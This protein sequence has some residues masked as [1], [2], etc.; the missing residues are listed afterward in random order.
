MVNHNDEKIREWY[1]ESEVIHKVMNAGLKIYHRVIDTREY[2]KMYRWVVMTGDDDYYCSGT[3]KCQKLKEQYS[4]DGGRYWFDVVP[5]EYKMGDVIAYQSVDCGYVPGLD[6]RWV[7]IPIDED[8]ICDTKRHVKYYKEKEQIT[9]DYGET[10]TDTGKV[11]RGDS[12]ET[13]SVDC[14]YIGIPKM[15][16]T[17]N[18]GQSLTIICDGKPLGQ[19]EPQHGGTPNIEYMTSVTVGGCAGKIAS[20]AFTVATHLVEAFIEEGVTEIGGS[21]FS[22]ISTLRTV[23]LPDSLSII[24]ESAFYKCGIR[25][26][27]IGSGLTAIGDNAFN[28]N[29]LMSADTINLP[30]VESIGS[31]AFMDCRNIKKVV[32]GDKCTRIKASAFANCNKLVSITIEATTP[33]FIDYYT[34][35]KTT[36]P[37]YVPAESVETYKTCHS[38]WAVYADRIQAIPNS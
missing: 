28:G 5:E 18:N 33:P 14:G 2:P 4:N 29:G 16:A 25:N 31:A 36:C 9:R 30:L 34:F 37:I 8:Y 35:E 17:Y 27:Q 22:Q 19:F 10:W 32:I 1:M 7:T 3:T 6:Y 23:S 38:N 21:T 15:Y 20:L 12:A 26:I 11:R 13:Q 24:G